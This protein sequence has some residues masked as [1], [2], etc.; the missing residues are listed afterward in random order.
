MADTQITVATA[1]AAVLKPVASI[2]MGTGAR[3]PPR[4]R[5][6]SFDNLYSP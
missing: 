2:A 6:V 4:L 1:A 3:A 5:T